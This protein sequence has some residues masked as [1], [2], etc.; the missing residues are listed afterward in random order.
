MTLRAFALSLILSIALQAQAPALAVRLAA[1]ETV[2]AAHYRGEPRDVARAKSNAAIEAYN[3]R[4]RTAQAGLEAAKIALDRD[5]APSRAAEAGLRDQIKALDAA[6]KVVPDGNDQ[7][8]NA[9]YQAKVQARKPLVKQL[10]ELVGRENEA[11]EAYNAKVRQTQEELSGLRAQVRTE[12]EAVDR[13]VAAYEAFAK[14]GGDVA[15][16]TEVNRLLLEARKTGDAAALAQVRALRRE[17]GAWATA[18]EARSPNGMVILEARIGEEAIWL[19]LDTGASDVVVGPEVL[20]AAGVSLAAGE[21]NTFVV[22]GG[23]RL[24]GRE[25]RLPRLSVAG[26]AMTQVPATAVH[27]FQVGVDGLL[28]QSFLKGFVYTIDDR[29]A[30]KLTLIRKD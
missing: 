12:R 3:A 7:E 8:G 29:K 18:L 15:F 25:V 11:L 20:E 19:V 6:L 27:S 22:V 10:N 1:A 13:R 16:C 26:Q 21:D 23:Q 2:M 17:L 5:L 28:G 4:T 14:D 24:R 30:E 9:R